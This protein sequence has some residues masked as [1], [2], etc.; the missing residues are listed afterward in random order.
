MI[1]KYT[2]PDGRQ[3]VHIINNRNSGPMTCEEMD[4]RFGGNP[5]K[6]PFPRIKNFKGDYK[7]F[8]EELNL[9]E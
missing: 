6:G 8:R 9:P 3:A 2:T 1:R 7:K 5:I 4:R